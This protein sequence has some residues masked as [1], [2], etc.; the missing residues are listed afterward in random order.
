MPVFNEARCEDGVT[1]FRLVLLRLVAIAEAPTSRT[2]I[3]RVVVSV[4][5]DE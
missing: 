2:N 1:H 5:V 3:L 4:V